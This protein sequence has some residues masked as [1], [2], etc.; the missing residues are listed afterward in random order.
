MRPFT[1]KK[2]GA[3]LTG[4]GITVGLIAVVAVAAV[5]GVG[6]GVSSL[7]G[8]TADRM[9]IA[10][11]NGDEDETTPP[12]PAALALAVTTG[13][14][15][16]MD[17]TGPGAPATGS[18]VRFTLTNTGDLASPVVAAAIL[19]TDSTETGDADNFEFDSG[20]GGDGCA[21]QV[22][23]GGE[24]CTLDVRPLAS[25]NGA[26]TGS[27]S[28]TAGSLSADAGL[29]GAA[30]GFGYPGF[31]VLSLTTSNGRWVL[32][33]PSGI[34][35]ADEI[36]EADLRDNDWM[37]KDQ[38]P[39]CTTSACPVAK[40]FLC[41]TSACRNLVP[42]STYQL[43]RAGFPLIGGHQFTTDG[44]GSGPGESK[45]WSEN[46]AFG[47]GT[48]NR[49]W[50]NRTTIDATHWGLDPL[51]TANNQTCNNWTSTNSADSGWAGA[52]G[53]TDSGRWDSFGQNCQVGGKGLI[54]YIDPP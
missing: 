25:A 19:A 1:S 11:G 30:D 3:S 15:D 32:S 26:F 40:A 4:Y 24:S 17:V 50:M 46:D 20:A 37:G 16:A 10:A 49:Y 42:N 52:Q 5:N 18:T 34:T 36:C 31:L 12:A 29:A 27:L 38:V 51:K 43:A 6:G 2:R 13:D 47:S 48:P 7:F 22:L 44:I 8:E 14:K 54:C 9:G 35:G 53:T 28:V 45:D 39:D 41:T 21:G 23:D 33:G